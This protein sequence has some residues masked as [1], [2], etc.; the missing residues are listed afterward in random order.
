MKFVNI[1]ISATVMISG[2][3]IA[4]Y[5]RYTKTLSRPVEMESIPAG[6]SYEGRFGQGKDIYSKEEDRTG[7][8]VEISGY[9]INRHGKV[10]KDIPYALDCERSL[11][12]WQ[13]EWGPIEVDSLAE[14]FEKRY[15]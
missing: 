4:R 15:C 14:A 7:S 3:G 12:K 11:R 13:G 8:I 10:R 5:F 1:L 2:F 6:Y 9:R